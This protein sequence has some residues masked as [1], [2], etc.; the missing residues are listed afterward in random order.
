MPSSMNRHHYSHKTPKHFC[1]DCGK[2]LFFES[3]L[4][5][6]RHC[7][8]KIPGYLCF[9]KN[10]NK[11]YKRE[12]ELKAH[13]IVHK[14]KCI[15]CPAK[16]ST[17]FTYDPRN[18]MQHNRQHM[19]MKFECVHCYKKFRYYEQKKRHEPDCESNPNKNVA[20]T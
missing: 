18:L 6:H 15:N 14:K 17:Y 7:H 10:C 20:K 13:V 11:S 9:E 1:V 3:E 8:L 5:S 19:P 12:S 16:N 4:T 2:G